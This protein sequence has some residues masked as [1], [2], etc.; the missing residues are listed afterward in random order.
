MRKKY[1]L[2]A[3]VGLLMA[4]CSEDNDPFNAGGGEGQTG[5]RELTFV[6]PGTAQGVVPYAVTASEAENE[7]KTLDIYVFGVDSM[8]TARP[9]VLE[10]IF[11]SG[12]GY[13]LTTNGDAK[14]AKISVPAGNQ[15]T[16]YFV[17]NAREHLSLDSVELHVTDTT[18]FKA[19]MSNTLKGHITCPMLMSAKVDM[20][21]V[22]TEVAKGT[23]DVTLTRRV[24]RFDIQ[25]NS[26]TSNFVISEVVLADVPGNAPLFPIAGYVAPLVPKLPVIDFS[27]MKNSNAGVTNSV[28]YMYPIDKDNVNK[29]G[30]SLVGTSLVMNAPQVLDVEF[31]SYT[32]KTK[33]IDI[34]A[35]NRYLVQVEDLGSGDLTATLKVIEWIVG[36][37]VNV[38]TGDGTIKLSS[39]DAGFADNTLTVAAEPTLTDSIAIA[40]AADGEWELIVED[41][42]KD[43]IGVSVLPGDTTLKEFKVTTLLPNP[44]SKEERQGVVMVQNVR[45][46]SIRQP[47]IVKQAA[48]AARYLDMSG[49]AVAGNLLSFSG[50]KT[51]GDSLNVTIAAPAGTAWKATKTA[52]AT[53][54]KFE[55][56][57]GLKAAAADGS[58]FDGTATETFSIVPTQNATDVERI[59]TVTIT[60]AQADEF[61]TALEQKLIVRQAA[62][63]LGAI[64]VS[65]I[66]IKDGHVSV[67]ADGFSEKADAEGKHAGERKV[68]V[69]ATSEW[70]VIIPEE[71]TWLTQVG[72]IDLTPG[73]K[74]GSFYLKAAANTAADAVERKAIVRVENTQ[75]ATIYQEITFTQVADPQIVTPSLNVS[76]ITVDNAGTTPSASTITVTGI[77]EANVGDWSIEGT[78]DWVNASLTDYQTITIAMAT[79][80]NQDNSA[81]GATERTATFTLKHKDGTSVQF[82]VTQAGETLPAAPE[83]ASNALTVDNDGSN[84]SASTITINSGVTDANE[85]EIENDAANAWVSAVLT[86]ANT[87]TVTMASDGSENNSA[88]TERTATIKLK[89]KAHP[90]ILVSFTVTQAGATI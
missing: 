71:A 85:W 15:K 68:K 84:L 39:E 63:N 44:S 14:T 53:W 51:D 11:R 52:S 8:K 67:A 48:N 32:D 56:E 73:S 29:V 64:T 3:L 41:Q 49:L 20:P 13:D 5:A 69:M 24:A 90:T 80:G 59:D 79:D 37:T 22:A 75:D 60:I 61:K 19:K 26:E 6:F 43:W 55:K 2:M 10:E 38:D 62:R 47:L 72:G 28:F 31:K 58:T 50:E 83:L 4:S 66:G 35:N 9:M 65:C 57:A 76:A 46:P 30:F 17:A 74:N 18:A 21:D 86:D 78:Y 87:I 36:D 40:V 81:T 77:V 42:Y 27:A 7:L 34:E 88:G 54:F 70:K 45:R 33:T 1:Y 25:N 82:T 23:I 89:N 12:Q 16:F